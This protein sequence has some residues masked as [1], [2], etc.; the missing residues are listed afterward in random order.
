MRR[1]S[2]RSRGWPEVALLAALALLAAS[3]ARRDYGAD[4]PEVTRSLPVTDVTSTPDDEPEPEPTLERARP[5]GML[6]IAVQDGRGRRRPDVRVVIRPADGRSSVHATTDADGVARA[7]LRQ[8]AYDVDIPVGCSG[9][10]LINHG[11]G[12]TASV[13]RGET[14]TATLTI[15]AQRRYAPRSTQWDTEPPWPTGET[16][17]FGFLLYDRCSL[18]DVP[19]AKLAGMSL[20]PSSNLRVIGGLPAAADQRAFATIRVRC[21]GPGDATLLLGDAATPGEGDDLL[22]LRPPV[23][24]LA[25]W[26]G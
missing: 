10:M 17:T 23:D 18:K 25:T 3:C 16:I 19:S 5:R 4:L 2:K 14:T 9:K 7:R 15:D 8:G 24:P 1:R 13:T 22:L 26:C 20:S 11:D 12:G 21:T 6:A